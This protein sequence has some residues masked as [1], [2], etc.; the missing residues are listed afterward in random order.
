MSLIK[1]FKLYRKDFVNYVDF[2]FKTFRDK[3]NKYWM[4]FNEPRVVAALSY[5]KGMNP[6]RRCSRA[7]EIV[8]LEIQALYNYVKHLIF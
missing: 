8:Q 7:M 4:T 5:G 1:G 3:L 6:P 2:C